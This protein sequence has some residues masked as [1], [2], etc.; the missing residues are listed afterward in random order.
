MAWDPYHRHSYNYSAVGIDRIQLRQT[1]RAQ[2]TA[3]GST[4]SYI[5]RRSSAKV[6]RQIVPHGATFLMISHRHK[7]TATAAC[8]LWSR[9]RNSHGDVTMD[10]ANSSANG[11]LKCLIRMAIDNRYDQL[12]RN[13]SRLWNYITVLLILYKKI[14]ETRSFPRELYYSDSPIRTGM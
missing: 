1:T 11:C 4:Y 6:F 7:S 12:G 13:D 3:L 10:N 14:Y 5:A 2:G 8:W 9:V